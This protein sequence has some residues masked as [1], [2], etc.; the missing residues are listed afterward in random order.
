MRTLQVY[1]SDPVTG[2]LTMGLPNGKAASID[3]TMNLLQNIVLFLKT[4]PNSDTFTPS[5]GSILGD[6]LGLSKALRDPTHLKV[7][8]ADAVTICQEF[9]MTQQQNQ[10]QNGYLLNPDE[11]LV[12]I[13]INNIY[14]SEDMANVYVELLV[15]TQGNKQFFVTI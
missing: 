1:Y 3:G 8:V 4:A 9:I 11:T 15:H 13:E 10:V 6:P 2:V 5:R 12:Q 14:Q 7:L